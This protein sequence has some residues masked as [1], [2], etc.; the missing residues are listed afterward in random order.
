MSILTEIFTHKHQEVAAARASYPLAAL[1][2]DAARAAPPLDFVASLRNNHPGSRAPG[3]KWPR[4]I[5]EIKRASPSRGVLAPD[6]DPVSLARLYAENG[7]AAISVLTDQRFFKGSLE[8][9]RQVSGLGLH[10]PVLRKDFIIDPYQVYEARAAGADAVL[11]IAAE[12]EPD[13]LTELHNL[14]L[15]LGMAPLVEVH[16]KAELDQVLTCK[17]VLIGIN[18]RNLH[19]FSINLETSLRLAPH[20]PPDVC[21][22]AESGIHTTQDVR[23]LASVG[24]NAILVGEALVTAPD[25]A[26]Q[27][28]S[29]ARGQSL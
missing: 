14:T 26:A 2:A 3:I 25:T 20:V 19:N 6:L 5:A 16:D 11:L 23:Q 28:R 24:V 7:A 21:L 13:Q 15:S 9:L 10:L 8:D 22:V 4:L 29:L 17:P 12:L 1:Q 27:V 18:N